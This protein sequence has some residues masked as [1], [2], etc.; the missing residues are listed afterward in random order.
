MGVYISAFKLIRALGFFII[1]TSFFNQD[2]MHSEVSFAASLLLN[3]DR[4]T[5]AE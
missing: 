4:E 1:I 3:S 2:L 5:R